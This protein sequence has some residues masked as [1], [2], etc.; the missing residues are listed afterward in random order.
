MISTVD[1]PAVFFFQ[2]EKTS[3]RGN[4]LQ[5]MQLS[6]RRGEIVFSK[7]FL[8]HFDP[9]SS[10]D[11]Q[12]FAYYLLAGAHLLSFY[13][14]MLE[15]FDEEEIN[16]GI[17][18][19]IFESIYRRMDAELQT[20]EIFERILSPLDLHRSWLDTG[21]HSLVEEDEKLRNEAKENIQHYEPE[22]RNR[23]RL[24]DAVFSKWD[25]RLDGE[26][27]DRQAEEAARSLS[28]DD[29]IRGAVEKTS[30]SQA[31][32][33]AVLRDIIKK[34]EETAFY[35]ELSDQKRYAASYYRQV[36]RVQKYLQKVDM[37]GL[38]PLRVQ[39]EIV[40]FLLRI[41]DL[42]GVERELL[43]LLYTEYPPLAF[44]VSSAQPGNHG[45]DRLV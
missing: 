4:L 2:E 12:R 16:H 31:T 19:P 10:R 35:Y 40:Y 28:E 32:A 30:S 20:G 1:L 9:A 14:H 21:V 29:R 44:Q 17:S 38:Y 25:E 39:Q 15:W 43:S 36:L 24:V 41:G 7:K 6:F 3:V 26:T 5:V 11:V 37:V 18:P 45:I 42:A 13:R 8:D 27:L 33:I 34:L 22:L 23:I